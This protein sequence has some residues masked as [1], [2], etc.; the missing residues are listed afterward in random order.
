MSEYKHTGATG[1][2]PLGYSENSVVKINC[3]N[4]SVTLQATNIDNTR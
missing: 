2:G 3:A 1:Q 4:Q